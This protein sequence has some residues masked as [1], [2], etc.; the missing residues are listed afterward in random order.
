M[1][2]T[3][4]QAI[5]SLHQTLSSPC[6]LNYSHPLKHLIYTSS[7]HTTMYIH[8]YIH[9]HIYLKN[10]I[11]VSITSYRQ[12]YVIFLSSINHFA[13][14]FCDINGYIYI[15]FSLLSWE[16]SVFPVPHRQCLLIYNFFCII[17]M[18][19]TLFKL[20]LFFIQKP[21]CICLYREIIQNIIN[22]KKVIFKSNS[23]QKINKSIT[24]VCLFC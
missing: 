11:E 19:K 23:R 22:K 9:P 3:L 21:F 10:T 5:A 1:Q 24:L 16:Q 7:I 8:T 18:Y 15:L 13:F 17:L 20:F 4:K 6:Y 14:T 12:L 2:Q